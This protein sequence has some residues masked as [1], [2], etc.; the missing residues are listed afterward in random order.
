MGSLYQLNA[1]RICACGQS[2][3]AHR[4]SKLAGC[5][6]CRCLQFQLDRLE[7][8]LTPVL[9]PAAPARVATRPDQQKEG[10]VRV[11]APM[12]VQRED[13]AGVARPAHQQAQAWRSRQARESPN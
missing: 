9:V 13:S 10:L 1:Y 5:S 6:F 4:A 3:A 2:L 7:R 11:P 8:E 12:S